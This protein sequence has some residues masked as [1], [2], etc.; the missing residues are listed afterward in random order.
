MVELDSNSLQIIRELP[1]LVR[2]A[3]DHVWELPDPGIY[4]SEQWQQLN[5]PTSSATNIGKDPKPVQ[6]DFG[7]TGCG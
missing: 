5:P 4:R 3:P 6:P 1:G 2:K 7:G